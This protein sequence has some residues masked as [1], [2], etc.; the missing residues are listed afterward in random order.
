MLKH[1]M[2]ISPAEAGRLTKHW[3]CDAEQEGESAAHGPENE[4]AKGKYGSQ[5]GC[6]VAATA[7]A[8]SC[9]GFSSPHQHPEGH[10]HY[11]CTQE[12]VQWTNV[13]AGTRALSLTQSWT[14]RVLFPVS[15]ISIPAQ[16]HQA[17]L[18]QVHPPGIPLNSQF[19]GT[20]VLSDL[21]IIC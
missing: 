17:C 10:Q 20:T 2:A 14:P 4:E 5:A 15:R 8:H 11:Q 16:S 1:E 13:P 12:G 21:H 18:Q 19:F 7:A 3:S 6:R 9:M